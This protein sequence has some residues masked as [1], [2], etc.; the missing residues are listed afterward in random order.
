MFCFIHFQWKVT[1][2][3]ADSSAQLFQ[4]DTAVSSSKKGPFVYGFIDLFSGSG[5]SWSW[6]FEVNETKGINSSVQLPRLDGSK[7]M[8]EIQE[9]KLDKE[10]GPL[11]SQEIKQ[12]SVISPNVKLETLEE[13]SED[14][15]K[16]NYSVDSSRF[17]LEG[18]DGNSEKTENEVRNGIAGFL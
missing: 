9:N 10:A 1:C 4:N 16:G 3:T 11:K 15:K 2:S 12:A 13:E 7:L 8:H 6:S 5:K 17:L 18:M 14:S